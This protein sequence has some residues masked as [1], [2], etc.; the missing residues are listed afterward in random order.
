MIR[1]NETKSQHARIFI[2]G[3]LSSAAR[4]IEAAI[5]ASPSDKECKELSR[6]MGKL[7]IAAEE[8]WRRAKLEV[9]DGS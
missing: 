4:S 2:A 1:L 5:D 8:Y 7:E 3:A 9:I 6:L